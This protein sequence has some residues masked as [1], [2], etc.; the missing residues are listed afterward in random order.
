MENNHNME[1]GSNV[2]RIVS[3][4]LARCIAAAGTTLRI[5]HPDQASPMASHKGELSESDDEEDISVLYVEVVPVQSELGALSPKKESLGL[6]APLVKLQLLQQSRHSNHQNPLYIEWYEPLARSDKLTDLRLTEGVI[7][8]AHRQAHRLPLH[9]PPEGSINHAHNSPLLYVP[10]QD[11]LQ[12]KPIPCVCRAFATMR[13]DC[14]SLRLRAI[15]TPSTTVRIVSADIPL[16][17]LIGEASIQ[18]LTKENEDDFL[19]YYDPATIRLLQLRLQSIL[20]REIHIGTTVDAT[21]QRALRQRRRNLLGQAMKSYVG[22]DSAPTQQSPNSLDLARRSL[23]QE[24]CLIVHSPY[25]AHGKTKLVS[26]VARQSGCQRVHVIR[27]GPLLAKYGIHADAALETI[28]HDIA[29]A[30]AARHQAVCIILDQMDAMLPANMSNRMSM[31]D[32]SSPV[33]N[34]VASYIKQL[35]QIIHDKSEVP[36]PTRMSKA[37]VDGRNGVVLS[38]RLC[39]VAICTC[40]DDGRQSKKEKSVSPSGT[41]LFDSMVAGRFRLPDLSAEQRLSVFQHVFRQYS[42]QLDQELVD[43]LPFLTAAAVW[44]NGRAFQRIAQGLAGRQADLAGRPLSVRDFSTILAAMQQYAGGSMS[45]IQV[46]FT[47]SQTTEMFASVGG[48]KEAKSTLA[49]SLLLDDE[50]RS[51]F[52][53]FGLKPPVGVLLYGIPGT[54]KTLLA[55]AV[56][57]ILRSQSRESVGGAFL[58]IDSQ[59]I[60]SNE[61][62]TGESALKSAFAT[63]KAN[64]PAVVFIDEFQALFVER[65]RGGTGR[66]SSTLIHCMD[67]LSRW[68]TV[69]D[70]LEAISSRELDGRVLVLAAT[71]TPWMVD[72]AFLRPGRFDRSVHVAA[73]TLVERVSILR[74]TIDE[75]QHGL[76]SDQ[77]LLD[78]CE[79]LGG[80]TEGFSGAD[81]VGLCRAAAVEALKIGR[82]HLVPDDYLIARRTIAASTPQ[83]VVTRVRQWSIRNT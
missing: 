53:R 68:S 31:A 37:F 21:G 72:K 71:N 17:R 41:T 3:K 59:D 18:L 29:L 83:N 27:P 81:L 57:R 5:P 8:S 35:S 43:R 25:R 62:G 34:G 50:K 51:V 77:D 4:D 67:E 15:V 44:V 7:F 75:M 56:A 38:L 14:R 30:S 26:I 42:L 16:A 65:N 69:E 24:S 70:H 45:R 82:D 66:L 64:S 73:P 10:S 48:N 32:A 19:Q 13:S 36:F 22:V 80:G 9:Q 23:F 76:S 20:A 78:L 6:L 49:E 79:E 58:S 54:G 60:V 61:V 40:P 63:A 47:G 28:I 52:R 33:L 11:P 2:L 39:L 46:E 55:K 74:M 1:H 12:N